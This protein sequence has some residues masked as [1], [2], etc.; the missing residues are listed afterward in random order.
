MLG[1]ET[2]MPAPEPQS[3]VAAMRVFHCTAGDAHKFWSITVEAALHIV[4]FG[5]IG[6]SGQ[7]CIKHFATPEEA[8]KA[9]QQL[10]AG[11]LRKGY[12]EVSSEEAALAQP[13]KRSPKRLWRQLLLP[14]DGFENA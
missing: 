4:Q 2:R 12:L 3:G 13:R 10:I 8:Q 7:T 5:R 9:A 6:R 14:F 1:K 11:K